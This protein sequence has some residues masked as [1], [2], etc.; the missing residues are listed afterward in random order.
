MARSCHIE[1]AFN[2]MKKPNH[3]PNFPRLLR[4]AQGPRIYETFGFGGLSCGIFF[5]IASVGGLLQTCTKNAR[6]NSV[7]A[8]GAGIVAAFLLV[9]EIRRRR[10]RAVLVLDGEQLGFYRQG[11]LSESVAL[12]Q[13]AI[14]QVE[15]L[16]GSMMW[17][18][19]LS[20]VAL[21]VTAVALTEREFTTTATIN[22]ELILFSLGMLGTLIVSSLVWTW[23]ACHR[24]L[25]LSG[26]AQ[27]SL[28]LI[29][30]SSTSNIFVRTLA[31]LNF[32][33]T[34]HRCYGFAKPSE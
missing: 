15:R 8:I 5:L 6:F 28:V 4:D 30:P 23:F 14:D 21:V 31:T 18:A 34:V 13:V 11:S 12:N 9:W 2:D 33:A 3:N 24:I 22:L 29:R 7:F 1:G 17:T 19:F 32:E 26:T 10:R 20:I 25:L 16:F 27:E